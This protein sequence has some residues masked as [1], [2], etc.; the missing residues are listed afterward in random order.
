MNHLQKI[1]LKFRKNIFSNKNNSLF[2]KSSISET[3]IEKIYQIEKGLHTE[4]STQIKNEIIKQT[5]PNEEL[6]ETNKNI[7][8]QIEKDIMR[9]KSDLGIFNKP[10]N[11]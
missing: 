4:Q 7:W 5:F 9:T 8:E 6:Y 3:D 10:V 11:G 2:I 1:I